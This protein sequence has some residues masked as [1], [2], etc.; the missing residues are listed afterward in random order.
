MKREL[1]YSSIILIFILA[2]VFLSG[3]TPQSS[4]TQKT[5][6]VG[7]LSGLDF[8]ADTADGFKEKMT[9]LGYVEGENIVYDIQKTDFDMGAYNRILKKFVAD[10]VDLIFV[11]PTEASQEAKAAAQGTGIPVVFANAFT[12]DTGLINS[13]REP[14]GNITGVRWVGPDL[15]LKRFEIMLEL[16]PN[17]KRMWI[18]YQKG[19]PI[20][21]SQLEVLRPAFATAGLTLMELPADNATELDAE[22]QEQAT[23][24]NNDT[25]VILLIAEPLGV[26]PEVF[27]VLGQFAD[28]HKIPVGGAFISV[29]GYDS[30]FGLTPQNIPQGKQ[31][32]ILADKIFKG[33]PAGTIPVV[34]ADNFLQINYKAIQKL[35]LNASEGL[36]SRADQI[37]H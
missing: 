6:H 34:S 36:L 22:L 35:G 25:D 12:E 1:V 31:A 19:Y 9:E 8:F 16:V 7:I 13:V 21:K 28:E 18:P 20:V 23:S 24:F 15:A 10:K 2:F 29:G 4:Q 17:A 33:V 26:T 11:F 27:A 5:Y 32:A 3:Y 30:V 14:G 37:I